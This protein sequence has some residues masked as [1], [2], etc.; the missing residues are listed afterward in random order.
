MSDHRVFQVERTCGHTQKACTARTYE[1]IT[2]GTQ[3]EVPIYVRGWLRVMEI[4]C[5]VHLRLLLLHSTGHQVAGTMCGCVGAHFKG[6]HD[7]RSLPA[8]ALVQ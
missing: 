7:R 5:S 1:G 8:P 6:H 3:N 4:L 2:G